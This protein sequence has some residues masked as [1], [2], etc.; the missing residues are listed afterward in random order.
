MSRYAHPGSAHGPTDLAG[1]T[2]PAV[3]EEPARLYA[4]L[5]DEAGNTSPWRFLA[6]LPAGSAVFSLSAPGASFLLTARISTTGPHLAPVTPDDAAIDAWYAAL[7]SCPG[8][9]RGDGEALPIEA[10][11]RRRLA[12][13]ARVTARQVVWLQSD[14]PALRYAQASE[15]GP[16]PAGSLLALADQVTAEV[17]A[18]GEIA[19]LDTHSAAARSLSAVGAASA[20]PAAL[21]A[22]ALQ[23]GDAAE[24]QRWRDALVLDET[25]ASHALQELRDIADFRRPT[26]AAALHAGQDALADALAV[27]AEIEHFD[28]RG[29]SD[30]DR[31]SPVFERLERF[32][33]A[34]GFRFRE[35]ALDGEWW[36]EEGPAFLAVD[37][38][39][40]RPLAV[41]WRRRGWRAIDP[42]S[43][44]VIAIDA[45]TAAHL[46]PRGYTIY[47]ALPERVTVDALRR[48]AMLGAEGD[49]AR[50]LVA[51]A[52]ATLAGLLTPVATGAILGIAVPDGRMSLLGDMVL[53][54]VA[55]AVGSTGFQIARAVSLIRFSTSV[56]RRLQAAIWDRVIRLRTGFFRQ[57]SVGDLAQRIVGIDEIRRL[58]SG[59]TVTATI[60]G[61]FSLAGLAVMAIYDVA[62]T[63]FA[64]AYAIVVAVL[65][66]LM[67]RARMRLERVVYRRRGA[68]TGLLVEILGGIAKL[69]IAAAELRAF[70]R[71]SHAFA[72]QRIN[73]AR[74]RRLA[75]FQ[76]IAVTCLPTLGTLGIFAIANGGEQ[77]LD[78][79]SFAAFASAFSQFTAAILSLA[80]ASSNAI[81]AL[82]LFARLRPVLDAE[83]EV[84]A[85]RAD[86]GR[87]G[88][89]LAVRNLS[90]RYDDNAPWIL[91]DID[92]EVRP[93]ENLAIVGA[94]GSGKSTLLRLLLGFE[95]PTRGGVFYDGK[96]LERL[97]LRPLRRQIGTVLETSRLVP[98]SIYEN[99]AGSAPFT[100]ERVEEAVR[101]AGLEA[102]VAAMPM[103]LETFVMEGGSQ[104]SGGQRQRVMI[105]RA[106]VRRP[107][108]IF[109]DEATSALDNRTQAIVGESVAGMNATRIVIAHRLSTIRD[110]DRIVVLER[111]RIAE[112]GTY[113]ELIARNGAFHRLAQRQLL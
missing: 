103:G 49:L 14:G 35:I 8:I 38:A 89:R 52:A 15:G 36:R 10:G 110:A 33:N 72:Q 2:A 95:T 93:G 106:L 86:P 99:I 83:L 70:S 105:A 94:S 77:P 90:F 28:V 39:S 66:F 79:A 107:R 88:G 81:E 27:L 26:V 63:G 20:A 60:A 42:A 51:A 21:I 50:L 11:E 58:I 65:L 57:Y 82:P 92:I 13:G 7:L 100:R 73:S 102:D 34:S 43:G 40:A 25:R 113:D 18:G 104:L 6:D 87:L 61:V 97:D 19:T 22:A 75:A 80:I 9:P 67:G 84:E 59:L 24:R 98:G 71:W 54:L 108:L 96:D 4:T 112:V 23:A 64:L 62:L 76:T 48:F 5:S 47:A 30:D 53:M 78:V 31:D 55:A 45:H 16:A 41:V 69:R 91:E 68:V 74:S 3:L 109:L 32:A 85:S 111:G 12:A 46:L 29:P 44:A 1:L 17:T 56:N 37:A 101:L